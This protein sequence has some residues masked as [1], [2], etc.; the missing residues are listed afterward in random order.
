MGRGQKRAQLYQRCLHIFPL[1]PKVFCDLKP[2][3]GV[4]TYDILTLRLL[5][6]AMA[7]AEQNSITVMAVVTALHRASDLIPS[8]NRGSFVFL[9]YNTFFSLG[10]HSCIKSSYLLY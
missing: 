9:Q 1:S 10:Q 8:G 4:P 7:C 5:A 3:A 6:C 2:A